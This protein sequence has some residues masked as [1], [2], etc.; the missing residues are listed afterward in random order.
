[1]GKMAEQA[2]ALATRPDDL[3]S[4][5]N[6]YTVERENWLPQLPSDVHMTIVMCAPLSK[7]Q[8]FE[9]PLPVLAS[10]DYS[11]FSSY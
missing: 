6:T 2:K 10:Y 5:Y 9:N 11:I 8:N 3:S 7:K 4:T 1:M